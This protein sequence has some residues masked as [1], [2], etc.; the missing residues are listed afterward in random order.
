MVLNRF[1]EKFNK[2][3]PI[4]IQTPWVGA[5]GNMAEEIYMGLLRARREGKKVLFIFPYDLFWKFKFSKFGN[6]I[7]RDLCSVESKY[8]L[9]LSNITNIILNSILTII[10]LF[11]ILAVS[12]LKLFRI[13]LNKSWSVPDIGSE[14]LWGAGL[15]FNI[16]DVIN[17][18][19]DKQF[20]NYL[21]V[22]L[23]DKKNKKAEEIIKK[24]GLTK[25]DWFVCLHARES[26]YYSKNG[27]KEG[28]GKNIRN[29]D[30]L[31]YMKA[32]DYILSKGGWVVR[33]G[34]NTMTPLPVRDKLIDYAHSKYKSTLM[35]VYLLQNCEFFLGSSSG[36]W[37]IANLFQKKIIMPNVVPFTQVLPPRKC[38][39]KIDK[40]VY[41]KKDGTKLTINDLLNINISLNIGKYKIKDNTPEEILDCVVSFINN[42][43]CNLNKLQIFFNLDVKAK[44]NIENKISRFNFINN[45]RQRVKQQYRLASYILGRKGSEEGNFL[46]QNY[47]G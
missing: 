36:I 46:K 34:D 2:V 19:W 29:V 4:I 30:P 1:F 28:H 8:R 16:E 10:Y 13:N 21:P 9:N 47:N 35:D 12:F 45:K 22:S 24:I 25:S 20:S 42:P 6:G 17:M 11:F 44:I 5:I 37:D 23:P 43:K 7:N 38:D 32:V 33:M 27:Y 18:E 15:E 39:I 41:K 14:A 26:G 31:T 3:S 40:H